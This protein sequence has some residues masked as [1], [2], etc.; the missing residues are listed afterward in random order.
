MPGPHKSK[1]TTNGHLLVQRT[2]QLLMFVPFCFR[3]T[4]GTLSGTIL[5][6]EFGIKRS[7]VCFHALRKGLRTIDWLRQSKD[8][9]EVKRNLNVALF[10]G[11]L[12]EIEEM[13]MG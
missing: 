4:G 10:A 7:L 1:N 13:Y 11:P 9:T 12:R 2:E 5:E 3:Y 6:F 8:G